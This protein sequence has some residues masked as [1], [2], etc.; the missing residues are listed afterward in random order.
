MGISGQYIG[1]RDVHQKV[2]NYIK[3][4]SQ[5]INS[6]HQIMRWI[7]YATLTKFQ[8]N[9]KEQQLIQTQI[10]G[11]QTGD[12]AN[13]FLINKDSET[14]IL[15]VDLAGIGSLYF[16]EI[17]LFMERYHDSRMKF[18]DVTDLLRAA[19]AFSKGI[20]RGLKQVPVTKKGER[21]ELTV[22]EASA[23]TKT[24]INGFE[25]SILTSNG[26]YNLETTIQNETYNNKY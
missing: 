17:K 2:A 3:Q 13:I 6:I 20:S 1:I 15:N 12:S 18:S 4:C 24:H 7:D 11:I 5:D 19:Y 14:P 21:L 9:M 23:K 26:F 25:L 8:T 10:L 22:S 16:P